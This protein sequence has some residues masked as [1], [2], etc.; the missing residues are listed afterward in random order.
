MFVIVVNDLAY[1][2]ACVS[3]VVAVFVSVV[4]VA[5]VLAVVVDAVVIVAVFVCIG[6]SCACF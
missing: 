6:C 4:F 1:V 5:N 3:A 2:V